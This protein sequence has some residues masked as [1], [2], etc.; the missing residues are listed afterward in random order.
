MF[1]SIASCSF[2]VLAL[3]CPNM[4]M[5]S[6]VPGAEGVLFGNQEGMG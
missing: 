3:A 6:M 2:W 1:E 4:S 5:G